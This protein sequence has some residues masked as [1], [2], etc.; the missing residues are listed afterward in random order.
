MQDI[1]LDT[2]MLNYKPE[3][4]NHCRPQYLVAVQL[5]M[6]ESETMAEVKVKCSRLSL[7]KNPRL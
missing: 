7:I 4:I 2:E 5:C 3:A 6:R 1:R